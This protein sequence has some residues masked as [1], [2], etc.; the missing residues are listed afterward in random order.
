MRTI[1]YN[2]KGRDRENKKG[3]KSKKRKG[4][5]PVKQM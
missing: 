5:E 3:R 4:N 2:G 1:I